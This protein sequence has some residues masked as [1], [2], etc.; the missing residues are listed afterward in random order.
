MLTAAHVAGGTVS[1]SGSLNAEAGKTYRIE[2]FANTANDNEGQRYLGYT[3]VTTPAGSPYT[4][5]FSATLSAAVA[6]GEYI[7]AT[8][9]DPAGNTSEF[10]AQIAA[11][12][13]LAIWRTNG[14]A[15]P[16]T[17]EWTGAAFNPAGNS[18]AIGDLVALQA[19]AAPTRD[20][21]IVVGRT[22]GFGPIVGEICSGGTW[23][24]L[25][26]NPLGSY[27]VAS[28]WMADVAYESV[29]GDAVLV[30][31]DNTDLKFSVWNGTSWTAAALLSDYAAV[32]GGTVATHVSLAAKPGGDELVL[33]VT[34][35]LGKDYAFVWNGSSWSAGQQFSAAGGNAASD[36]VYEAQSGRAMLVYGDAGA[37]GYYRIWNGT[38]WSAQAS[39]AAPAGPFGLAYINLAADPASNRIAVAMTP[40]GT[41]GSVPYWLNVW[42]GSD[43]GT[44]LQATASGVDQLMPGIDV[45]FEST[46]RR[47]RRR[48]RHQRGQ[49]DCLP[50]LDSGRRLVG[51]TDRTGR[52]HGRPP[53]RHARGRSL[54][55]PG[56]AVRAGWQ[57]R[58]V[59]GPME[60]FRLG[61]PRPPRRE[62]RG[63]QQPAVR[64]CLVPGFEQPRAG[65][66]GRQCD[67]E[68]GGHVRVHGAVGPQQRLRPRRR[69][70]DGVPGQRAQPCG[71]VHPELRR[72]VHLPPR[73]QRD[74][75]RQLRLR[76]SDGKGGFADATVY[77][78]SIR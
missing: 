22:S 31:A 43:W 6:N 34:D 8:A 11:S 30:W 78:R 64:V 35:N 41:A 77:S 56:N 19:A 28:S 69:H 39:F 37:S 2:F 7:T 55:R 50:D 15:S 12:S 45:A 67:R 36:V 10:S 27:A 38:S 51:G 63:D 70:A 13:G 57:Q 33:A 14:D 3:T 44:S 66:R 49:H 72:R 47:R 60:R 32:S 61:K 23:S 75:Q 5:T 4:V 29:S 58:L 53:R 65:R 46:L 40:P 68:R 26:I 9:T 21:I 74:H 71:V 17:R 73:R 62:H 42:D 76:A 52:V 59:H 18:S 24:A 16:N 20:E 25:P 48:L 54:F 1:I